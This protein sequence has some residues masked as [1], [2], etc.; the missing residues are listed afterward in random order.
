MSAL[1]SDRSQ[2][3]VNKTKFIA[4]ELLTNKFDILLGSLVCR[5]WK[6]SKQRET[7]PGG[8]GLK[9]KQRTSDTTR[10]AGVHILQSI[11]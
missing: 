1:G 3:S 4:V 9:G 8:G 5:C 2:L 10:V 7:N 11:V 6:M